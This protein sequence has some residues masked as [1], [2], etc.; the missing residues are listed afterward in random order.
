MKKIVSLLLSLSV[1]FA[2]AGCQ[3]NENNSS[4]LS[5]VSYSHDTD[6]LKDAKN[7]VIPEIPFSLGYD[8]DALKEEFKDT[9]TE[10]SEIVDLI[11]QSGSRTT[12][13]HGGNVV[14][15]YEN[16]KE[17]EGIGLIAVQGDDAYGFSM[18]GVY[19]THDVIDALKDVEYTRLSGE[20]AEKDGFLL[21]V[22]PEDIECLTYQADK[23]I[24][25]FLFVE[26]K[27]AVV[28]IYDPE[29]WNREKSQ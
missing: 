25:K 10:G 28:T 12:Q 2:L 4:T 29:L 7:G 16:A 23:Y 3:K 13:L 9:L 21:P 6:I 20:E 18:G 5:F 26:G 8:I 24:L 19:T 15:C 27:L 14:F 22:I 1:L 17:D 11:E